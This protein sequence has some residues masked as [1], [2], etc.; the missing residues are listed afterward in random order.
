VFSLQVFSYHF[1]PNFTKLKLRHVLILEVFFIV[2]NKTEKQKKLCELFKHE[3]REM[4]NAEA[5][6]CTAHKVLVSLDDRSRYSDLLHSVLL[7]SCIEEV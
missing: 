6:S 3:T 4:F 2:L 7:A 1:V 5:D